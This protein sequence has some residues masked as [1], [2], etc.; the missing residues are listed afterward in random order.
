MADP[1]DPAGY[2]FYMAD[3]TNP[4]DHFFYQGR[5]LVNADPHRPPP[6]TSANGALGVDADD[7]GDE[8][9]FSSSAAPSVPAVGRA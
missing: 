9:H 2:P 8:Q 4:A 1:F 6:I 7:E 5:G 3:P